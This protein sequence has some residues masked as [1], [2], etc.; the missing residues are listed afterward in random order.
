MKL[1]SFTKCV[2]TRISPL[3]EH[4]ANI[5]SDEERNTNREVEHEVIVK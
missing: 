2:S 3:E 1:R 4:D 5:V